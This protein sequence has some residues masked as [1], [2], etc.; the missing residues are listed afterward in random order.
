MGFEERGRAH[1]LPALAIAALRH[2]M[3]DPR[4][5]YSRTD[6]ITAIGRCFDCGDFATL[7][8]NDRSDAGANGLAIQVYGAGAA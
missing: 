3:F 7:R 4:L 1:D 5:V 2:V 8:S 6:R